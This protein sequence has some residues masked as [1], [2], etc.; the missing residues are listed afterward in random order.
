[1]TYSNTV[2]CRTDDGDDAEIRYERREDDVWYIMKPDGG[3]GMIAPE[4]SEETV[5]QLI[6][7]DYDGYY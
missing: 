7:K 5:K 6:R 4:A 2:I 1:M 3:V